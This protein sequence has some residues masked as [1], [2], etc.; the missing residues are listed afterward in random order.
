MRL[1]H[2]KAIVSRIT[3][4]PGWELEVGDTGYDEVLFFQ[5]HTRAPCAKNPTI[6][7]RI[8]TGRRH[9]HAG[10][11]ETE[12]VTLVFDTI[13]ALELHELQEA[14]RYEG[15]RVFNPHMSVRRRLEICEDEDPGDYS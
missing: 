3:Y 13:K 14:F 15:K 8:S 11:S 5:A 7:V 12:L 10:I 4:K 9:L 2:A 1:E 6:T